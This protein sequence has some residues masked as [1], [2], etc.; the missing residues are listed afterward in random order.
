MGFNPVGDGFHLFAAGERHLRLRTVARRQAGP[1][2]ESFTGKERAP[3]CSDRPDQLNRDWQ[4]VRRIRLASNQ[5]SQA[6]H[7]AFDPCFLHPHHGRIDHRAAFSNSSTAMAR[8][9]VIGNCDSIR[10]GLSSMLG[11]LP[12]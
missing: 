12:D 7:F 10:N 6:G 11:K 3:P 2:D 8:E 1:V 4:G 5:P 9:G